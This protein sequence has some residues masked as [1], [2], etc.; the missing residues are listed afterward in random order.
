MGFTVKAAARP[1]TYR[2]I[3]STPNVD[4]AG[5]TVQPNWILDGYR[6][7]GMP[8]LFGHNYEELPIG[9]GVSIG[10]EGKNLVLEMEFAPEDAYPFAGTVRR[11]VDAGFINSVSVGF[12]PVKWEYQ[13]R[14]MNIQES[15]LLEVSIVAVPMNAEA[16]LV[17]KGAIKPV[18]VF[19]RAQASEGIN[20]A[21][22][23]AW[24]QAPISKGVYVRDLNQTK[25]APPPPPADPAAAAPPPAEP[26]ETPKDLPSFA[27]EVL[28]L[29]QIDPT[30]GCIP[31]ANYDKAVA[32]LTEASS[33]AEK[34]DEPPASD[35]AE[36]PPMPPKGVTVSD[37]ITKR[38]DAIEA[39]LKT[40]ASFLTGEKDMNQ[41]DLTEED[42][43]PGLTDALSQLGQ[44]RSDLAT[45][46]G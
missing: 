37:A 7:T 28:R 21:A 41:L 36:T 23:E 44:V 25:A 33:G 13:E 2:F 31:Q 32:M 5:D 43:N 9:R 46:A 45:L 11:L 12:R 4:R 1:R 6:R 19:G 35:A 40:I 26:T 24:F 42:E 14:G 22:V 8:V 30:A 16:V 20:R 34:P 17:S 38:I 10:V 29:L 27:A 39:D 15:E 18:G 3:A